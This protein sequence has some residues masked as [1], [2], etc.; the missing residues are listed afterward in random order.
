[1]NDYAWTVFTKCD[2]KKILQSALEWSK[3]TFDK[4]TKKEPGYIDTYANILYK[5]GKKE[6]A[7][8]WER[9]AQATAVEQG[10]DKNW[11]QD[12]IDKIN[13]GEPT[14]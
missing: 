11:G 4:E 1:L 10:S 2:D 12:V 6:E 3:L 8:A 9:K 14:W 7:L 13:K 5:L